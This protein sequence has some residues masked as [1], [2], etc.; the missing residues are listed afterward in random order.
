MW[1]VWENSAELFLL[2]SFALK[3]SGVFCAE[4]I[5]GSCDV[6][7]TSSSFFPHFWCVCHFNVSHMQQKWP[8]L[9][10]RQ[11]GIGTSATDCNTHVHCYNIILNTYQTFIEI[12]K[13]YCD[14][15]QYCFIVQPYLLMFNQNV[16]TRND[17]LLL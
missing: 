7:Q 13:L 8:R 6:V 3:C 5:N 9:S 14:N 2:Y 10:D 1:F 17:R 4:L 12:E 16:I 15:Y 11:I